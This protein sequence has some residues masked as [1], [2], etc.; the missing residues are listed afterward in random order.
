MLG[1]VDV[2]VEEGEFVSLLGPSGCGKS[3]LLRLVS[4][5][6]EPDHGTISVDGQPPAALRR[7]GSGTP[8]LQQVAH[9]PARIAARPL[10]PSRAGLRNKNGAP[11]RAVSDPATPV[12]FSDE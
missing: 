2:D 6:L 5:L 12:Y 3:T 1:G 9:S 4:G 10:A 11:A 7:A 8:R